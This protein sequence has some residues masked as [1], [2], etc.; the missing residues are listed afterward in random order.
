MKLPVIA[1]AAVG[2]YLFPT[3]AICADPPAVIQIGREL[4]KEGR[5][6]AHQKVE[7]DWARA[8]RKAKFPSHYLALTA[9][10]GPGEVWFLS[11]YD[12]FAAMEQSDKLIESGALKNE[13]DLLEARDGE[14]RSSSRQMIAVYRKDLS[15]RPEL[16]KV[17]STRYMAI[18]TFRLKL[19]HL[20]DFLEGSK[21]FRTAYEKLN[22]PRAN[23]VYQVVGGAPQ[24]TFL[25]FQPMETLKALDSMAQFSQALPKAMG[26]EEFGRLTKGA[27]DVFVSIETSFFKVNPQMSYVSKETEDAD[28]SY[29]RPK[30][31]AKPAAESKPK[32]KPAQ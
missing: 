17:G 31:P 22:F 8:F 12:S 28:P 11:S 7:A 9:M 32:E 10:T 2:F 3:G 18:S 23:L 21:H 30:A 5:S 27:G 6:S 20:P 19:G 1:A 26:V 16:T 29:W 24:D 25:F 4:T 13:M 14:M 15:Y